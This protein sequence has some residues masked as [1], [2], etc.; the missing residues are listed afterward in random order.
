MRGSGFV[1]DYFQLLYYNCH[2]ISFNRSASYIDSPDWIKNKKATINPINKK[3]NKCFQ[4]AV[5][6][7][8]ITKK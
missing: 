1:F 3:D 7:A 6:V 2:E 4:Y 8:F 5:T